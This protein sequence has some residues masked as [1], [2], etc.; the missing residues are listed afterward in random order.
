[1]IYAKSILNSRCKNNFSDDFLSSK[2]VYLQNFMNLSTSKL[3]TLTA[4]LVHNFQFDELKNL[5]QIK[6]ITLV[7]LVIYTG[8]VTHNI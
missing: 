8:N 1:M 4:G 6:I 3:L 2:K 5:K 7:L